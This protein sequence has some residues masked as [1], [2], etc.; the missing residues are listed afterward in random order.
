MSVIS[1]SLDPCTLPKL[2]RFLRIFKIQHLK[3]ESVF[4]KSIKEYLPFIS[5]INIPNYAAFVSIVYDLFI[6][7]IFVPPHIRL[8]RGN[9]ILN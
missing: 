2:S 1:G 9:H 4:Y 6:H 3:N 5:G 8:R 7:E